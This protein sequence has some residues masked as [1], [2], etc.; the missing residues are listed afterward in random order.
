MGFARDTAKTAFQSSLY[1]AAKFGAGALWLRYGSLWVASMAKGVF[2]LTPGQATAFGIVVV[3]LLSFFGLYLYAWAHPRPRT[4][5]RWRDFSDW[6][7]VQGQA[8]F[9]EDIVLDG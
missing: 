6:K 1:D 9:R 8:F 5:T 7:H 4:D 3:L 2:G